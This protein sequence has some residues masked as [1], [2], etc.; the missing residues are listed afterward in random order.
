MLEGYTE[1]VTPFTWLLLGS[2]LQRHGSR[3]AKPTPN[4]STHENKAVHT[5]R[6]AGKPVLRI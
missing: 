5:S 2:W 6:V 1:V 3:R 4:C